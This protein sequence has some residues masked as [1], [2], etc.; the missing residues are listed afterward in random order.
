MLMGSVCVCVLVTS[1]SPSVFGEQS[2]FHN[3]LGGS[4]LTRSWALNARTHTTQCVELR[5]R[6]DGPMEQEDERE[7]ER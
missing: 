7:Q 6:R 1:S 4:S 3:E 2:Q 5:K